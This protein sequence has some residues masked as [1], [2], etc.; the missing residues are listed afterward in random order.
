MTQV[1]VLAG[2]LGTRIR[3]ALPPGTPK[4]MAPVNGVPFLEILLRRLQT[5]GASEFIMLLGYEAKQIASHF[6][7]DFR[8]VPIGY[9]VET[10]P[11]GTGGAVSAALPMLDHQFAIVN[12]DTFVDFS[13]DALMA[14]L[15]KS[16]LGMTLV[17][18]P[19]VARF[20]SVEV[21]EDIVVKLREKGNGGAGLI[22][23]GA[24]AVRRRLLEGRSAGPWSFEKDILEKLLDEVAPRFVVSAPPFFDIGVP[25][26]YA[27]ACEYFNKPKSLLIGGT[28]D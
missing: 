22:N 3:S 2:G 1:A 21:E 18:V 8:G 19:N 13:L 28:R 25:D 14:T 24:Y 16:D 5:A 9:S 6:G 11:L 15:D 12:G 10:S 7:D 23:A 26:D 17:E 20:G 27:L 4:A